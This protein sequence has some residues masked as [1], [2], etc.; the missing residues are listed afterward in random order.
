ML[1]EIPFPFSFLQL[2]KRLRNFMHQF[3]VMVSKTDA[4]LKNEGHCSCSFLCVCRRVVYYVASVFEQ[5]YEMI[6]YCYLE[7]QLL[8]TLDPVSDLWSEWSNQTM[9]MV[10]LSH[11]FLPKRWTVFA[12][13]MSRICSHNWLNI[14][15]SL[16]EQ[17]TRITDNIHVVHWI[18]I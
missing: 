11:E 14:N 1:H 9:M 10:M 12:Q 7:T 2:L 5:K 17:R 18:Q 8:T 15:L 4:S 3:S 16:E 6:I 13:H